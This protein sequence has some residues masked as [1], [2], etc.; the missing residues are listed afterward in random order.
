MMA[1][2]RLLAPVGLMGFGAV[3]V[4]MGFVVILNALSTGR[5]TYSMV[6]DG[7]RVTHSVAHAGDHDGYWTALG[8]AGGLPAALGIGAM[9]LGRRLLNR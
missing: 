1:F 4:F 3:A 2:V 9:W 6:E 8:L 5:V 7:K